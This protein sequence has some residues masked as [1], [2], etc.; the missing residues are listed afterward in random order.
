MSARKVA[1]LT[2][3]AVEQKDAWLNTQLKKELAREKLDRRDAALATRICLGCIQTQMKL[4]FYIQSFSNMKLRKMESKVRNALRLSVYQLLY[5]ERIPESAVVNEAVK[6]IKKFGKNP[7]AAG[8]VNGILR[9]II[10]NKETLPKYTEN[11]RIGTMSLQYSHPQWLIEEFLRYLPFEEVEELFKLHNEEPPLTV[12]I[13]TYR[14][15]MQTVKENLQREDVQ[16]K[17]HEWLSDSLLL[18]NTGNMEELVSFQKGMFYVQDPA[19]N[20]VA[21][22]MGNIQGKRILDA[23]A[24]PG[25]KSFAIGIAMKNNGQIISC[26]LHPHKVQLIQLGAERLGLTNI[27]PV[28]RDARQKMDEWIDSFDLVVADVPCS[29]LGVIR[30]KPEIRYKDFELMKDLPP[31]QQE[32]LENQARY[33]KKGGILLYATCTLR[34]EENEEIISQFLQTHIDF[35]LESFELENPIGVVDTGMYTFWPH[36]LGTDG[37][38]VAKLR[39]SQ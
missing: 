7:R 1:L 38:F 6:L 32:I 31:I 39:R 33:V 34:K 24:A 2:L 9:N 21:K 23:C 29:G 10:R 26:D 13:N 22:V 35:K 16:V 19:A 36:R 15:D 28:L 20:L 5:M 37:F 30:K 17:V 3:D 11:S 14:Y 4:D 8:M 27:Q 25:G 12:Q 18:S